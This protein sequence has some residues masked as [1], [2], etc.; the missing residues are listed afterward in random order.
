MCKKS[1]GKLVNGST[2][3]GLRVSRDKNTEVRKSS[4]LERKEDKKGECKKEKVS[5]RKNENPNQKT[6]HHYCHYTHKKRKKL[7][8]EKNH[9]M[10]H[11]QKRFA[12]GL[13]NT[14]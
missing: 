12:L 5:S 11:S 10:L 1:P 3:Q 13:E 6:I 9:T 2:E 7:F 4:F 8:T 14:K